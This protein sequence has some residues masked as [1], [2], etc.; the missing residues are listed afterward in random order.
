MKKLN[1]WNTIHHMM[2]GKRHSS[3]GGVWGKTKY[4]EPIQDKIDSLTILNRG[5]C[6]KS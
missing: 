3:R 4:N 1:A 6:L 2:C 5:L